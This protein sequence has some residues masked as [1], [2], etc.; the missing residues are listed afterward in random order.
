[1]MAMPLQSHLF[2]VSES[3]FQS[4]V[5]DLATRCGWRVF[6][7]SDSRMFVGRGAMIG[8]PLVRGWPDLVLVG[9]GHILYREL[10]ADDNY[11]SK[12]QRQWITALEENGGDVAVWRPRDWEEIEACLTADRLSTAVRP[13]TG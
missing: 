13:A 1:M 3:A 5:I 9:H 12:V 6:H 7:V 4:A 11:P 8:D 2:R 10:K